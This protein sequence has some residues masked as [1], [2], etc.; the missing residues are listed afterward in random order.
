[1]RQ[2]WVRPAIFR[3]DNAIDFVT[4]FSISRD[5]LILSSRS[6]F[7]PHFGELL[8]DATV[9][10]LEDC[11]TGE[12][13]FATAEAL[14][15]A[16][17]ATGNV[18]GRIIAVGG[19]TVLNMAKLVSLDDYIPLPELFAGRRSIRRRRELILAPSSCGSGGE[20]TGIVTLRS[21]E[22]GE[23]FSLKAYEF[24]PDAAVLIPQL[25]EGL[26]FRSFAF[27]AADTFVRAAESFVSPVASSHT[28]LFARSAMEKIL[29]GFRD[30]VVNGEMARIPLLNS[31]LTAANYAGISFGNVG[32]GAVHALAAPLVASKGVPR[33][34]ANSVFFTAVFT[35]FGNIRD[36]IELERLEGVLAGALGCETKNVYAELASLFERTLPLKTLR[37]YGVTERDLELFTANVMTR[38][39]RYMANSPVLLEAGDI[40][41]IYE[42]LYRR[43]PERPPERR[44]VSTKESA[45][46]RFF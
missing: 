23:Y 33:G 39:G 25:L 36:A 1:M 40:H 31:F 41:S 2:F 45:R 43:L 37:E 28:R 17:L 29:R 13:D 42:N 35:R 26:P 20:V 11:G 44:V 18:E 15:A 7:N 9:V 16:V 24:Y 8:P 27:G 32:G 5:D 3:Y 21:V 4:D 12:S 14:R 46:S 30:I 38:Q 22:A 34:E 6:V 19:D 10:F